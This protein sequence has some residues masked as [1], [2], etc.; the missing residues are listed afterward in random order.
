MDYSKDYNNDREPVDLHE[1]AG[2]L[3]QGVDEDGRKEWLGTKK[4][5]DK[6]EELGRQEMIEEEIDLIKHPDLNTMTDK[7]NNWLEEATLEELKEAYMEADSNNER[8][9]I[10]D[11]IDRRNK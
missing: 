11:E 8:V 1:Q 6:Y 2:L 3:F 9:A 4:Q 5:W 10:A 7:T